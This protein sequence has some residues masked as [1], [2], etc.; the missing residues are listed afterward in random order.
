LIAQRTIITDLLLPLI[1][2]E[3]RYLLESIFFLLKKRGKKSGMLF[4]IGGKKTTTLITGIHAVS[5]WILK[6]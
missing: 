5:K 1:P 2:I 4:T 6:K 3:E